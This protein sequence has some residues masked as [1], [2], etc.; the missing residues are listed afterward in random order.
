MLKITVF[1]AW[2]VG[3]VP[4]LAQAYTGITV[5]MQEQTDASDIFV[6]ELKDVLNHQYSNTLRVKEQVLKPRSKLVVAENSELVI[7]IGEQA[8]ETAA[9][10]SFTTPVLGIQVSMPMLENVQ[11]KS[12]RNASNISAITMY[13]P[14]TRILALVENVLPQA[15]QLGML[16]SQNTVYE[17]EQLKSLAHKRRLHIAFSQV[18]F[19]V[20]LMSKLESVLQDTDALL[21]YP[22]SEVFNRDTAQ[23]IFLTSYRN[24]KPVLG[25]TQSIV[26]AGALA[27]VFSDSKHLARQAAEIA[28]QS[29]NASALLPPPQAPKYFTV[30]VNKQVA[31]LLNIKVMDEALLY[32]T[33]LAVETTMQ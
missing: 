11:K 10:L 13:Q 1:F 26:K 24:K 16:V 12:R 22:D 28:I 33:M 4:F 19:Q 3:F 14:N 2:L 5:V 21:A 27:A 17:A 18:N 25:C 15:R 29:Q 6:A 32:K 7:A 20:D 31:R 8:F 30:S 9:K 23:P